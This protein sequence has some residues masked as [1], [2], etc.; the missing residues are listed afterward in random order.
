M[1]AR[2]AILIVIAV[3]LV[4]NLLTGCKFKSPRR[5]IVTD[6]ACWAECV[7]AA[8]GAGHGE[9]GSYDRDQALNFCVQNICP[10]YWREEP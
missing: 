6:R 3:L 7:K 2:K 1:T 9:Y 5:Y 10:G 8:S 4:V